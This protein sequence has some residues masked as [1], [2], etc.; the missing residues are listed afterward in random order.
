MY[1]YYIIYIHTNYDGAYATI[2]RNS[3]DHAHKWKY[4]VLI[5]IFGITGGKLHLCEYI[6]VGINTVS[7]NQSIERV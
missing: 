1:M 2:D 6:Y 5:S 7:I 3:S 4:I